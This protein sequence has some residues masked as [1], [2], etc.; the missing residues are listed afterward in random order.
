ML[1]FITQKES[2]NYFLYEFLSAAYKDLKYTSAINKS[3]EI[4]DLCSINSSVIV[5]IKNSN[6]E[7]SKKIIDL[8]AIRDSLAHNEFSIQRR[9]NIFLILKVVSFKNNIL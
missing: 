7:N 5:S 9:N 2:V 3:Y 1:Y 8:K 6:F 4:E